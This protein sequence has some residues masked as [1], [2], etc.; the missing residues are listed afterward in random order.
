MWLDAV[1]DVQPLSPG[2][3][4]PLSRPEYRDQEVP[5]IPKSLL[6]QIGVLHLS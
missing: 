1:G 6:L 5:A 4:V 3:G 2:P